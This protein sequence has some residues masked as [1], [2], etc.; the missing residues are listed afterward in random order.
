MKLEQIQNKNLENSQDLNNQ[1]SLEKSEK[2][3]KL[4]S[5]TE[6]TLDAITDEVLKE[7]T[8]EITQRLIELGA[9]SE[10]V[11][12]ILARIKTVDSKIEDTQQKTFQNF[13]TTLDKFYSENFQHLGKSIM[14]E[15]RMRPIYKKYNQLDKEQ[16]RR[17]RKYDK[18]KTPVEDRK[19]LGLSQD[20]FEN[21]ETFEENPELVEKYK[22][23][24]TNIRDIETYQDNY[25]YRRDSFQDKFKSPLNYDDENEHEILSRLYAVQLNQIRQKLINKENDIEKNLNVY[26]RPGIER[27]INSD[28]HSVFS[29]KNADQGEIWYSTSVVNRTK[30]FIKAVEKDKI[31]LSDDQKS[32]LRKKVV[33]IFENSLDDLS[34]NIY[35]NDMKD[36]EK[37]I[38]LCEFSNNQ[39]KVLDLSIF[40]MMESN[41]RDPV[42]RFLDNPEFSYTDEQI[43]K[44]FNI[45][46]ELEIDERGIKIKGRKQENPD[47]ISIEKLS[48]FPF[49]EVQK[50][51]LKESVF[52]ANRK[53]L[54]TISEIGDYLKLINELKKTQQKDTF[55]TSEQ[56]EELKT[57]AYSLI[58]ETV[59]K[60]IDNKIASCKDQIS[61]ALSIRDILKDIPD[62]FKTVVQ[63]L[64]EERQVA[65]Q[66]DLEKMLSIQK[67]SNRSEYDLWINEINP[68]VAHEIKSGVLSLNRKEDGAILLEYIKKVGAKNLPNYFKLFAE[69][70]RSD[71]ADKMPQDLKD[72][73]KTLFSIH[74]DKICEK[75]PKNLNL[76]INEME[77]F[78]KSFT[79]D[80]M[81]EKIELIDKVLKSD[82]GK[83]FL[84]STKG[85]SNHS[86]G[87]TLEQVLLAYKKNVQ[88]NPKLFKLKEGY[89]IKQIEIGEYQEQSEL[90]EQEIEKQIEPILLNIDLISYYERLYSSIESIKN[91]FSLSQKIKAFS[92]QISNEFEEE[93]NTINEKI[94]DEESKETKNEK[95]LE[96]LKKRQTVLSGQQ[97]IFSSFKPESTAGIPLLMEKYNKLIP[98]NFNSKMSLL[99][100][101]SMQDMAK[102][103]PD[104]VTRLNNREIFTEKPTADSVSV[105]TEFVRSH[106]GEHYLNKKHGEEQAIK[107]ED[108]TLLKYLKKAWGAQDFEKGILAITESK[109]NLLQRGEISEKKKIITMIPSKGMQRIFSGDL[110]GACTSRRNLEFAKG[111]YENIVSYSLVL[112]KDTPKERFAGSFLIVET[113]TENGKPILI[114]RANNPQQNLYQMIDTNELIE[115]TIEEVKKVAEK[116][117]I[118]QVGVAY[119][120]GSASNRSFVVD[121]YQKN[122]DK[123]KALQLKKTKDTIFNGYDIYK[124]SGSHFTVL[125]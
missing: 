66:E 10:E 64:I 69:I 123:S 32:L 11:G 79:T 78:R 74:V 103:F 6:T 114:L 21:A 67:R 121:Y 26:F 100:E 57:T 48:G 19:Y 124:K 90:N 117:G 109:L 115:K 104:Q 91:D 33:D 35:A 53:K 50:N 60:Y 18:N 73:I 45:I 101:L 1:E 83:E 120:K 92:L 87:G 62:E 30:A 112:D 49:T 23:N 80:L 116:R 98:D 12:S 82:I 34:K 39:R 107:T 36:L 89:E 63:K 9:T 119:N 55:L 44:V 51:F 28:H 56:N 84:V 43:E 2:I 77:K 61:N 54:L 71:S 88:K 52:N 7:D 37:F 47:I 38:D 86:Q 70:K 125:I 105:L 46:K 5:E 76:V 99:L 97:K 15:I 14:A 110:G 29:K 24:E 94:Q 8:D 40:K 93:R 68:L 106:V 58:P 31:T 65:W 102:I 113:K 27:Y 59:K 16:T 13:Y 108:K 85:N 41:K 17:Y 4:I 81:N 20:I 3:I 75:D 22:F 96:N 25:K 122:F 111:E 95:A 72:Y 118:S 42:S